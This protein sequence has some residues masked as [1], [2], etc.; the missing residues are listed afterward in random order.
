MNPIFQFD[1]YLL[2]RQVLALAGTF[3]YFDPAGNMVIAAWS[4]SDSRIA[5]GASSVWDGSK[6]AWR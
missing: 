6:R 2:K 3:R 5:A 1:R 4:A